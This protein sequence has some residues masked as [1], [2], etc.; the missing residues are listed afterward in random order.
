MDFSV[1]LVFQMDDA[2]GLQPIWCVWDVLISFLNLR[3]LK[4]CDCA[5][6]CR[7]SNHV[8]ERISYLKELRQL[9]VQF[10]AR[11][12]TLKARFVE[13]NM[14]VDFFDWA[15]F[16]S[17]EKFEIAVSDSCPTQVLSLVHKVD[18]RDIRDLQNMEQMIV[19]RREIVLESTQLDM[20]ILELLEKFECQIPR[21]HICLAVVSPYSIC[22]SFKLIAG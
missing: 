7:W 3:D 2:V 6:K 5:F 10:K 4:S 12:Q 20:D 21:I 8:K 15:L 22:C 13:R 14:S 11:S 16:D 1:H 9:F 19:S 18:I 17:V